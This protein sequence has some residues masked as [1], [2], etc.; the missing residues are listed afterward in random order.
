MWRGSCIFDKNVFFTV[1]SGVEVLRRC[2]FGVER[3]NADIFKLLLN[4]SNLDFFF[5]DLGNPS[6]RNMSRM[7]RIRRVNKTS[8]SCIFFRNLVNFGIEGGVQGSMK[9]F[10][11]CDFF[12]EGLDFVSDG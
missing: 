8:Q 10:T 11:L 7:I 5:S 3:V 9:R 4:V 2:L 1:S 12:L 6:F